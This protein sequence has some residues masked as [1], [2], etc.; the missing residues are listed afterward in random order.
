MEKSCYGPDSKII[1]INQGKMLE[2]YLEG[3][4]NR[5][6]KYLE[7]ANLVKAQK[8]KRHGDQEW[9]WDP[10]R[11]DVNPWGRHI[12]GTSF[13]DSMGLTIAETFAR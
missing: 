5:H 2:F 11:V 8:H 10:G 4:G 3:K 1:M 9:G 7:P 12:W 6:V 13:Q